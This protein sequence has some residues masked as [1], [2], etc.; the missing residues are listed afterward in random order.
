MKT[1]FDMI[2]AGGAGA[3][4]VAVVLMGIALYAISKTA[5]QT[6]QPPTFS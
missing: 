5:P 1:P 3:L 4:V 2:P 6:P